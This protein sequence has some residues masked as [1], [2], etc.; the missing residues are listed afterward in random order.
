[1]ERKRLVTL[2]I[3]LML[4]LVLA[5]MALTSCGPS[6]PEPTGPQTLLIGNIESITGWFSSHDIEDASETQIMADYINEQGGI[7][8][9]GQQYTIKMVVEDG[10]SSLDGVTAAANK[11]VF[12]H[13]VKF[14]VAPP[15]FFAAASNPITNAN[16]VLAVLNYN[17]N[18]PGELDANTP[19][20][21]IGYNGGLGQSIAF[22]KFMRQAWPD[23]K[24]IA[25][26]MPDDGTWKFLSPV[27][28]PTLAEEGFT[29]VGDPIFYPNDIVDF[30]P[31]ATKI[32]A[33]DIDGII[34]I[35]GIGVHAGNLLKAL[36]EAG[37][38]KPYGAGMC[39]SLNSIK[40]ISGEAAFTN[41]ASWAITPGDPGNPPLL[42]ELTKRIIAKNGPDVPIFGL[43]ANCL[44][45]LKQVI[46]AA[47]SLDPT[48]VKAKFETMDSVDTLYGT[49]YF[50]GEDT[51]GIR[52]AIAHPSPMSIA[53]ADGVIS[54]GGFIPATL[55][56]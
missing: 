31:I 56:P 13:G 29:M 19:Y 40:A 55:L 9:G 33:M 5:V 7:T 30:T 3:S 46:E 54:F 6:T 41:I 10:Q 34:Q 42:N 49:G 12:D 18:T 44:Y 47:N 43:S 1:M 21:F 45:I 39:D 51:Y 50:C 35:H 52:H 15:I 48:V 22:I 37:N 20:S 2:F 23:A 14:T 53:R 25:F 27:I 16:K 26:I 8:V 17:V 32:N 4:A 36:R 28:N 38:N 24:K 11:L